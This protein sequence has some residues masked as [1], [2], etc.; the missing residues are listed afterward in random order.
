[1]SRQDGYR[2]I[3]LEL[4]RSDVILGL[5]VSEKRHLPREYGRG[6]WKDGTR[7]TTLSSRIDR[8]DNLVNWSQVLAAEVSTLDLDD[9]THTDQPTVQKLPVRLAVSGNNLFQPSA[10]INDTVVVSLPSIDEEK[11]ISDNS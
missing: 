7:M 3:L 5:G 10:K 9:G 1:M 11:C 6:I 2:I 4:H 8:K